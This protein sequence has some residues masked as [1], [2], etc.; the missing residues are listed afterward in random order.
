[1]SAIF[2]WEVGEGEVVRAMNVLTVS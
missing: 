1:L 2:G